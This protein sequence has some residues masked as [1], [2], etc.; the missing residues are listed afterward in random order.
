[1]VGV[2]AAGSFQQLNTTAVKVTYSNH[3]HT[4]PLQGSLGL[5]MENDFDEIDRFPG[6]TVEEQAT[7]VLASFEG[8][9]TP[10]GRQA[11]LD[12]S[13]PLSRK[14]GGCLGMICCCQSVAVETDLAASQVES[15]GSLHGRAHC[16]TGDPGQGRLDVC[17]CSMHRGLSRQPHHKGGPEGSS[18]TSGCGRLLRV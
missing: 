8:G 15:G 3:D 10:N 9:G 2:S 12:G 5:E 7:K 1:M 16:E 17:I 14:S 11:S 13:S 18:T 4:C 6:L